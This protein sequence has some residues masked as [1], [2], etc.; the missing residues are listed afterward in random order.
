MA[1][2]DRVGLSV[3]DPAAYQRL[4]Y[5]ENRQRILK[6][7][8]QKRAVSGFKAYKSRWYSENRQRILDHDAERRDAI[9]R[10]IRKAKA[11]PC[12]DCGERYPYYVMDLDHVRGAKVAAVG[13]MLRYTNIAIVKREIKKCEAVCSNC[14]R[15][16][17]YG[18]RKETA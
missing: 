2:T 9:R 4:Y 16:R 7:L 15:E 11:K 17:T 13:T 10:L 3:S 14:H 18:K 6:Q 1:R 12:A 5:R 8:R